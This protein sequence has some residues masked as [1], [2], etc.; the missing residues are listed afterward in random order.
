MLSVALLL[1]AVFGTPRLVSAIASATE[2]IGCCPHHDD[3]EDGQKKCC[4]GTHARSDQFFSSS[5]SCSCGAT[6]GAF[7]SPAVA[8]KLFAAPVATDVVMPVA[9]PASL[10]G[11]LDH[12]RIERPPRTV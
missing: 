6:Q 7:V 4:C 5:S 9:D 3:G 12:V 1:F 8:N 11:R 10:H 2:S